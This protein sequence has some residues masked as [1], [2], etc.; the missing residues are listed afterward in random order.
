MDGL[1]ML[2][3]D[4][5]SL[6]YDAVRGVRG[7]SIIVADPPVEIA[8]ASRGSILQLELRGAD[9]TLSVPASET[10]GF[11]STIREALNI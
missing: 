2:L 1:D 11:L 7:R 9:S 6:Y 8:L 10:P 3:S 5:R 4:V